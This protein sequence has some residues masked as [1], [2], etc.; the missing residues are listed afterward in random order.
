MQTQL[1]LA[2]Y[3]LR[4]GLLTTKS[5][6]N[7]L[8]KQDYRSQVLQSNIHSH[9]FLNHGQPWRFGFDNSTNRSVVNINSLGTVS[10][11]RVGP[12]EGGVLSGMAND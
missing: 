7:A 2:R 5:A 3:M 10:V 12:H 1:G 9:H 8:F 4:G 6:S 11:C